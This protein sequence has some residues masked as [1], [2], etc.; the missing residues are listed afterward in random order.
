M[1]NLLTIQIASLYGKQ[2]KTITHPINKNENCF[3]FILAVKK[4]KIIMLLYDLKNLQRNLDFFFFGH[5]F[6]FLLTSKF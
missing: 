3:L 4:K 1:I 2:K 5:I 6:L